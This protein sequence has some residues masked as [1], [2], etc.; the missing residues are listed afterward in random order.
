ML[1]AAAGAVVRAL[2]GGLLTRF[3][4]RWYAHAQNCTALL[5]VTLVSH[6]RQMYVQSKWQVFKSRAKKAKRKVDSVALRSY[7]GQSV[8]KTSGVCGWLLAAAHVCRPTGVP[9]LQY[10]AHHVAP[11]F[12]RTARN[13]C[14]ATRRC[15]R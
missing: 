4:I 11:N 6:L 9:R 2:V 14:T 7:P 12:P 3:Q 15:H 5:I 1:S 8:N 10:D 13:T